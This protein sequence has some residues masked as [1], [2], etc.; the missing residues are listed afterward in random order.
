MI[1]YHGAA[2]IHFL[3]QQ[4]FGTVTIVTTDTGFKPLTGNRLFDRS[5]MI[6]IVINVV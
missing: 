3:F 2:L 6:N 1:F 4:T 5:L